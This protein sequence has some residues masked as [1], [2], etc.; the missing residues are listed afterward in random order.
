M[1]KIFQLFLFLLIVLIGNSSHALSIKNQAEGTYIDDKGINQRILSNTQETNV[2][3]EN[4]DFSLKAKKN[5]IEGLS[6]GVWLFPSEITNTGDKDEAYNLTVENLVAGTIFEIYEDLNNNGLIDTGEN[7]IVSTPKLKPNETFNFIVVI[8]DIIGLSNN[9]LVEPKL[10][11]ITILTPTIV[12]N[13]DLKIKVIVPINSNSIENKGEIKAPQLTTKKTVY[14]SGNIKPGDILLYEIE[15]EN[16]GNDI[17]LYPALIDKLPEDVLL[18]VDSPIVAN[19]GARMSYSDNKVTWYSSPNQDSRYIRFIWNNIEPNT[20]LQ[21]S[22]KVKVKENVKSKTIE[23]QAYVEYPYKEEQDGI[24]NKKQVMTILTNT[25]TNTI[26]L[27]YFVSGTVID[28]K[29]GLPLDKAII[30]VIDKNG[31]EVANYTTG[32][33]GTFKIALPDKGLYTLIYQD[34]KGTLITQKNVNIEKIGDNKAPIEISGKVI[35]SQTKKLIA[36]ALVELIDEKG[37]IIATTNANINGLYQFSRDSKGNE[38]KAG[39]Y[40]LKVTK[41]DGYITYGRVDVLVKDG[42]VI[43]NLDL[44]VDPFGIVYDELGGLDVRIK[45]AEVRLVYSCDNPNNL[46]KLEDLAPGQS[47]S[48][49]I[50]TKEDGFYQYFLSK[51][52]LTFKQYCLLVKAEG[53]ESRQFIVRAIPSNEKLGKYMLNIF[54]EKAQLTVIKDVESIPFNVPMKPLKIFEI[55]KKVNKQT[56]NIGDTVIYTVDVTNKLKFTLKDGIVIDKLPEGFKYVPDTL[57]INGK[58]I[59]NFEAIE[60]MEIKIG[61]MPPD[62][63]FTLIY[64]ARTGIRVNGGASINEARVQALSPNGRKLE[65]GPA[66]AIVFVRKDIFGYNGAIIGRVFV[67]TN[68]NG[69]PD[70]KDIGLENV[71][72]YTSNGLRI[73]TDKNGKY[74]IPDLPPGDFVLHIDRNSLPENVYP[75]SEAIQLIENKNKELEKITKKNIDVEKDRFVN[76]TDGILSFSSSK[77]FEL[78]INDKVFKS[79]NNQLKINTYDIPIKNKNNDIKVF[80]NNKEKIITLYYIPKFEYPIKEGWIAEDDII[81]RVFIPESG[82]GKANFR[83]VKLDNLDEKIELG[84]PEKVL[85]LAFLFPD[86]ISVKKIPYITYP[87]IKDHWVRKIVEYE[88]GL[89]IIHGYPDGNFKPERNITRAEATKL[90]LVAMKSYDIQS[91]TTIRFFV[92]NEGPISLKVLKDNKIVKTFYDNKIF[93]K[94]LYSLDW[95]GTDDKGNLLDFGKYTVQ[96][97]DDLNNKIELEVEI[98]KAKDNYRPEGKSKFVDVKE[99]HWAN[100]FIKAATDEKIVSGY[101]DN[102]FKP[103]NFIPRYE[104]AVIVSNALGNKTQSINNNLFIDFDKIPNWAKEKVLNA[105][106]N[107]LLTPFEDN[108]FRPNNYTTRAEVAQFIANLINTQSLKGKLKGFSNNKAD[109]FINNMKLSIGQ[110]EF[111]FDFDKSIYDK[112]LKLIFDSNEYLELK[113]DLFRANIK[114]RY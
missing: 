98:I 96:I 70:D 59:E 94:G 21:A 54:D 31:I 69:I 18:L 28:K 76:I 80:S 77:D 16:K 19:L 44:L 63:K 90:I 37:N 4:R 36:N 109:L 23:N 2:I 35:D 105:Y 93:K 42:D 84:K 71:E 30:K 89:E 107:N 106:S 13:N 24:I 25:A 5:E 91:F 85:G 43:V 41:A 108:T 29:T 81:R 52:Q 78:V 65:G 6:L 87:D 68:N 56:I 100:P 55:N 10:S 61:D 79:E 50:I 58:K 11:A 86:K 62:K 51:E 99:N 3:L 15:I 33:L 60:K 53:Y 111:E 104:L 45:N 26:K 73:L 74:S 88:S 57:S 113:D 12:K 14:P 103:D 8:K 110:G 75:V 67:D 39:T 32:K 95:D 49:P 66:K 20:K 7:K 48:N 92:N 40:Y 22:F 114:M 83:L 64:Q 102:T 101:N 1:K 34:E 97:I 112:D 38:L 46:V 72:L 82:L 27:E 47:Q 17:A 9:T